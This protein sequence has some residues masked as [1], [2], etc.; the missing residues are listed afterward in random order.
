MP[1]AN[2][3]FNACFRL[4]FN[5][6]Q[7][8]LF[9]ISVPATDCNYSVCCCLY[10]LQCLLPAPYFHVKL[11]GF[12]RTFWRLRLPVADCSYSAYRLWLQFLPPTVFIVPTAGSVYSASVVC[13][14]SSVPDPSEI[15]F[16]YPD[17][18]D[19]THLRAIVN[20]NNFLKHYIADKKFSLRQRNATSDHREERYILM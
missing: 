15:F 18:T 9:P 1:H 11:S 4:Y 5:C 16:S 14:H 17:F 8:T 12:F 10:F 2:C 3:V 7:P 13:V 19:P 20:E 6:W